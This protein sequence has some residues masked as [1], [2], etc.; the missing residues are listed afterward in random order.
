MSNDREFLIRVKADIKD[1]TDDLKKMAGEIKSS[2]KNSKSASANI[3]KMGRSIGF[4]RKAAA[5]YFSVQGARKLLRE[6]DAY[7]VLQQRIKT[8]TKNTGDYA[9][10]SR[11]LY[12]ISQQNGT[13]LGTSVSLFQS[14]ARSAPEL[15]ATNDEM[16]TLTDAVQQL[17]IISGTSQSNLNAGLLQFSQG[18]SS[19]IFRAEE[20]NSLLENIPE[21]ATRIARGMGLT[22]GELRNQIV[23]GKVLSKDVFDSLMKQAPEIS[24]E[25]GEI[26]VSME[27]AGTSLATSGSRLLDYLNDSYSVTQNIAAAMQSISGF[28]DDYVDINSGAGLPVEKIKEKL[29]ELK[30]ELTDIQSG[31]AGFFSNLFSGGED[32]IKNRIALLEKTLDEME[33]IKRLQ[34]GVNGDRRAPSTVSQPDVNAD[35]SQKIDQITASLKLQAETFGKTAEEVALYKLELLGANDAQM[36]TAQ[37]AINV[38]SSQREAAVIQQEAAQIV[39]DT[40]TEQE[41]LSAELSKLDDLLQK[42]A[43]DWDTYSR[44]VFNANEEFDDIE[45]KGTD[46]FDRLTAATR[47]WGDQ[48]T[49]T[50][51]DMVKTGKWLFSDLADSIISDLLRIYIQ[52]QITAPLFASF[53]IPGFSAPTKHTGGMIG[54]PGGSSKSINPAAFLNA[55]KFHTGG[56]PGLKK[57]EVPIIGLVGEEVLSRDDPRNALNGGLNAGPQKIEIIN[58]GTPQQVQ[59][60]STQF[61]GEKVVTKIIVDDWQRGGPIRRTIKGGNR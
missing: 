6:A 46:A 58:N 31:K 61:D 24:A 9:D 17:G 44:A 36:Q 2:A 5:T 56:F 35:N 37:N 54:A 26:E 52:Q 3:D 10:V 32:F 50:L 51:A 45:K 7:N 12:D 57:D 1:A 28:I 21:V 20:F 29:A 16:L 47:G 42:G 53:G 15:K 19:G 4:L 27:R 8:A 30:T 41:Q 25:F 14:L 13:A 18:L 22:T 34:D 48:F 49:N 39:A 59:S 33:K 23:A 40:R 11:R 60:A 43:I 55:Q 38:I